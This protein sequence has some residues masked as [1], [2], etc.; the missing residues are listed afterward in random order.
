MKFPNA[1]L[2]KKDQNSHK[3]IE[4]HVSMT[5]QNW[6]STK[7]F[8]PQVQHG[9]NRT[10]HCRQHIKS[11]SDTINKLVTLPDNTCYIRNHEKRWAYL[12]DYNLTNL[13]CSTWWFLQ[14]YRLWNVQFMSSLSISKHEFKSELFTPQRKTFLKS[15]FF[16]ILLHFVIRMHCWQD[17]EQSLQ[18]RP[19][20]TS[21]Q[22]Q[23]DLLDD[24]SV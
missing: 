5:V 18:C 6:E 19:R 7:E 21:D 20:E 2:C 8:L 14:I 24:Q 12:S 10:R 22:L 9:R 3:T 23:L 16:S 1:S 11:L 13:T 15:V 4:T 17:S